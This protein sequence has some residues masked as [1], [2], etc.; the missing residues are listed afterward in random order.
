M[1]LT[2]LEDGVGVDILESARRNA[3]G[4]AVRTEEKGNALATVAS[5]N[6]TFGRPRRTVQEETAT[7]AREAGGGRRVMAAS[8]ADLADSRVQMA[9]AAA[10]SCEVYECLGEGIAGGDEIDEEGDWGRKSKGEKNNERER[11]RVFISRLHCPEATH[12]AKGSLSKC[13]VAR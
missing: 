10:I 9:A 12:L 7:A 6:G 2:W 8:D 1:L 13:P 3:C 11:E 5:T 4:S